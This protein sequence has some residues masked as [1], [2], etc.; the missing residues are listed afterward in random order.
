MTGNITMQLREKLLSNLIVKGVQ[1]EELI[2]A[3]F[4]EEYERIE[5]VK[6]GNE[7][8]LIIT[9]NE[10]VDEIKNTIQMKYIYNRFKYLM[11]I[12]QKAGNTEYRTQWERWL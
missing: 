6:T 8:H 10:Y 9:F 2:S 4:E 1:P 3:I 11:K 12:E 7:I 5:C